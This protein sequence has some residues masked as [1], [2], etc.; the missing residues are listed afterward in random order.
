MDLK[1]NVVETCSK[2]IMNGLYKFFIFHEV[3]CDFTI[4]MTDLAHIWH[5]CFRH[6][7]VKSLCL[8]SQK[9]LAINMLII[10]D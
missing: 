5:R 6:L 9:G 1:L 4:N 3:L 10:P 7:N 2:D 8:L